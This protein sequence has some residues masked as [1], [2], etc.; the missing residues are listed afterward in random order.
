MVKTFLVYPVVF[1]C[2]VVFSVDSVSNIDVENMGC[3]VV[4][5]AFFSSTN[6]MAFFTKGIFGSEQIRPLTVLNL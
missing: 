5:I 6:C 4:L 3:D 1:Q 2:D